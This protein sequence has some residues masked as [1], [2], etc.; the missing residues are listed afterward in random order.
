MVKAFLRARAGLSG[1]GGSRH[2]PAAELGPE[3]SFRIAQ[4]R[5]LAP[6]EAEIAANP[7]SRSAKLRVAVRTTEPAWSGRES[8]FEPV[9]PLERLEAVS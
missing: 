9:V 8:V 2:E 3:P 1:G 6:G 7:R 5:A 4:R